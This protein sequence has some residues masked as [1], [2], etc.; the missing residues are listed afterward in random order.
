VKTSEH[1]E[2]VTQ[3]FSAS[4]LHN[5]QKLSFSKELWPIVYLLSDSNSREL[6]VGETTDTVSR[7]TAHIKSAPKQKLS[8]VRFLVSEMFNKSATLDI[9]S[10]L[11][12]YLSADG[13]FKIINA[14]IGLANHN[15][16]QK[17]EVY[18]HLFRSI[19]DKLRTTGI[20]QKP[21]ELIDNSD[22]F[23]Y[24][25]YKTLSKDQKLALMDIAKALL[26]KNK[27]TI[28]ARGG[29]GT[30]KTVLAIFIFKLLNTDPEEFSLSQFED[31][32]TE[33]FRILSS[34]RDRFPYPRMAL[35]IP[36]ASFRKTIQKVFKNVHG[37]NAKMVIGPA[38][39]EKDQF[40]IV[41]VDESHRLRRRVNLGPY[42][43]TF[44]QQAVKLRVDKKQTS[45]LDWVELSS[46][47]KILF[48]DE[49]QSIKPSDVTEE[50]FS[51]LMARASTQ[52]VTLRS[53]MRIR[54]GESYVDFVTSLLSVV[55]KQHQPI[56][57]ADNYE[58]VL[59]ES[60]P[61]MASM[62]KS[63]DSSFG[64]SRLVA[65]YAWPWV[66]KKHPSKYDIIVEGVK[67]KWN[68]KTEDWVNSSNALEEV[69]CIHTTQGYDLNFVGI[70]FGNEITFDSE[71]QT[72]CINKDKYHDRNGK[73]SIS[74]P[75]RLK[76]YILNIYKTLM[77]RAICGTFVYVAD[78]E[79]RKYFQKCIPT[80][81][82]ANDAEQF[83]VS[84]SSNPNSIPLYDLKTISTPNFLSSKEVSKWVQIPIE[85][86]NRDNYI[87]CVVPG[88][89]MDSTIP[90]GSVCLFRRF[91]GTVED[92]VIVLAF[93]RGIRE[94]GF[95]SG[96]TVREFHEA[97]DGLYDK[98]TKVFLESKSSGNQYQRINFSSQEAKEL[99]ILATFER[100][101]R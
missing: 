20:A 53:Q 1:F 47:K 18:W 45:E 77:T 75:Q 16:Y 56:F 92:G 13:R 52:V 15:Y 76:E 4:E 66:S 79:L 29:A 6:Y 95:R 21:L 71:S 91:I 22:L 85:L 46:V 67:L 39:L 26:S 12:K 27:T 61:E 101:L 54:G 28:I 24:S 33:F 41:I 51:K 32:D 55:D 81:R 96:F 35:V 36:M 38:Q 72:I 44:D 80:Y 5:Y 3:K 63:K 7:M 2:I 9:E 74:D 17:S 65:G 64:L 90:A 69:G 43:K 78:L 84:D 14:N 68:S 37:L 10:N 58:L 48:Y 59:F 82:R 100:V 40:D 60:L 99:E 49:R 25:P 11:I 94:N 31:E 86:E 30:G 93:Q 19:W 83:I 89:S 73:T 8:V 57:E 98:Q 70:I 88:R 42:F 23:K 34:L 62:I 87:A 97:K 50:Q